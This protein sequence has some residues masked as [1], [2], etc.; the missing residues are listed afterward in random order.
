MAR[1]NGL[2]FDPSNVGAQ[3]DAYNVADTAALLVARIL[4]HRFDKAPTGWYPRSASRHAA[5]LH[6][7]SG[8]LHRQSERLCGEDLT[9]PA[10]KGDGYTVSHDGPRATKDE[11]QHCPRC[12]G[13]GNRLGTREAN[14]LMDAQEIAVFYG[15]R[16]Y[17]QTDPRGCSLYLLDP[18][19]D[20]NNYNSGHAV[21]RLGR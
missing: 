19:T 17:H 18:K 6:V 21:C 10:C 15:L 16:A 13:R 7:I 9:C 20:D 3:A 4:A 8:L 11:P 1:K 5:R 12:K 14:L 2:D